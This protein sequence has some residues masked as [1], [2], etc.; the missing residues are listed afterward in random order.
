MHAYLYFTEPDGQALTYTA[1]SS[2]P[3]VATASLS[4][5][6]KGAVTV[7]AVAKGTTTVTVTASDPEGLSATQTFVATVP[8]RAPE[9]VGT[10]EDREVEADATAELNASRHFADPDGDALTYAAA[11]SDSA[12]AKFSVS[13]STVTITAVAAGRATLTVTAR[14]PDGLTAQQQ[15][16]VTVTSPDSKALV[17]LYNATNGLE[18]LPPVATPADDSNPP[19][20]AEMNAPEPRCRFRADWI[21]VAWVGSSLSPP[22]PMTSGFSTFTFTR[23]AAPAMP[24][25]S[26]TGTT[27]F[28]TPRRGD[29]EPVRRER[30]GTCEE[31]SRAAHV[32]TKG[33]G[34]RHARR[35]RQQGLVLLPWLYRRPGNRDTYLPV[36][37][38]V[39]PDSLTPSDDPGRGGWGRAAR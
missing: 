34:W 6:F 9:A 7:T 35:G 39:L 24:G 37:R 12:I 28:Q 32:A 13:G 27:G 23:P 2:N 5:R 33:V 21:N 1:T 19:S 38:R 31:P 14:D 36:H 22:I 18:P 16:S 17:A 10:I 3:G 20:M 26:R 11:S 15:A 25:S 29:R 30:S 8:N 4:G